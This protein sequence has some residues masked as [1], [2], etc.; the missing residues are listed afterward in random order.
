MTDDPHTND[1]DQGTPQERAPRPEDA[2]QAMP[3]EAP[4]RA[5]LTLRTDDV[6]EQRVASLEAANKSLADALRITYRL[7]L[8]LMVALV[9]IFIFTGV[10]QVN[11]SETGIKVTFGDIA[12]QNLPPGAHFN[13][14]FPLGEIVTVTQS[15]KNLSIDRTF[16]PA[17]FDP[18]RT[19][20]N[21]GMGSVNL[22]PGVDGSLITADGGLVHMRLS[23]GYRIGDADN[24]IRNVDPDLETELVKLVVEKA[25]V[26]VVASVNVDD[27]LSR[28]SG[29][30]PAAG[31][32]D[33]Q[34]PAPGEPEPETAPE[35]QTPA[36]GG[37]GAQGA[38]IQRRIVRAAQDALDRL[39][40]GI[41]ITDVS[42]TLVFPPLRVFQEF[43][44]VNRV[45]AESARAR[46]EAEEG[47]RRNL[48]AVAGSAYRPLLDLMDEYEALM[49]LEKQDEAEEVLLEIFAVF[50][51]ERDG[52]NV[53]IRGKVYPEV[54]FSGRSAEQISNARRT[55]QVT[56]D[57]A[58]R[59][60]LLYEAKLAQYR[61]NPIAFLARELSEGRRD[62]LSSP[63]VQQFF[64]PSESDFKIM[65]NND[66]DFARAFQ[67]ARQERMTE[68]YLREAGL[69]Q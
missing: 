9:F 64:V 20:D 39:G 5:S 14:P 36:S 28:S 56:V 53:E 68:T 13:L 22:R 65:L 48:N 40:A 62:F 18:R 10:K 42:L 59:A 21:P 35:G 38:D 4:R 17:G 19:L 37:V 51:G 32:D 2:Y 50:R 57:E 58:K 61:A 6:R 26:E 34:A 49:D 60:A 45:D 31:A 33:A 27:I 41:Q 47:R 69:E 25:T 23:V 8:V 44:A 63:N 29:L 1:T 3:V 54:F 30:T 24:Y 52:R 15:Q 55:S 7:I 46:E 16:V 43:Q 11:E 12:A 67:R 66:P